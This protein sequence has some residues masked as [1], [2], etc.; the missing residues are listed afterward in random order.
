MAKSDPADL[1][2][3]LSARR[4]QKEVVR[5][6]QEVKTS[7]TVTPQIEVEPKK[8]GRPPGR[9]SDP[10]C[11]SL[12]LLVNEE[13]IDDAQYK[14][15]KL[16]RGKSPKQSLSDLVEELLEEWLSEA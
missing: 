15:K 12:T 6:P 4:Q 5:V 9:R 1:T 8:V 2:Q 11:R 10:N 3:L 7:V 13:V 14:L 16:N